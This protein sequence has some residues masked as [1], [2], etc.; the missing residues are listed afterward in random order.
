MQTMS[1]RAAPSEPSKLHAE[2]LKEARRQKSTGYG[3]QKATG[4]PLSTVQRF[5]AAEV[6]PTVATLEAVAKALGL[7]VKVETKG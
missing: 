7:V 3:L 4:L 5:L 6:S 2:V 1:G